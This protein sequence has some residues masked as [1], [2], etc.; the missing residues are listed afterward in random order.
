MVRRIGLLLAAVLV[1]TIACQSQAAVRKKPNI[2]VILTDDMGYADL[3][4]Q[5]QVDDILT[6]NIDR[7]A[8]TGVR[9]TSGYV[10]APQCIPSR[11]GLLTGQYQNRFGVDQNGM[12]SLE[13]REVTIA[14]RLKKAG[15]ATGMVG[16]WHLNPNWKDNEWI[17]INMPGAKPNAQGRV[18]IPGKLKSQYAPV[19]QGF[20][21][22]FWGNFNDYT[23]SYNL[24][25][26]SLKPEGEYIHEEG[27]RLDIQ[28][29][30]GLAFI[31]RHKDEPF[32]L[33]LS[34][35]APHVPLDATEKY[36][37]RF[38]GDMPERRRYCLAMMSA[39][40][41]GVGRIMKRLT[42]YH[43]D[44]NT[45]VFFIS[46]NGA[47]LKIH[48]KD[49]P[50][51]FQG[52]AWDGSLNE[53]WV[54]EKGMLSEGGIR[55][56]FIVNWKGTLPAGKV[57]DKP[58]ISL[59]VAATA[60]H[61]AG[62]PDDGQLDGVNLIPYLTGERNGLPHKALFWRFWNQAAVRVG[63]WKYLTAGNGYE[64]LFNVQS[65]QHETANLIDEHREM[66]AKMRSKL[67]DWTATLH[68]PG[69]P[70]KIGAE[71]AWYNHYLGSV[72]G[73]QKQ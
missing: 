17:A 16:K 9:M 25:G 33:Y 50:I 71:K 38:P 66:T 26:E 59:D 64:Y 1:T 51:S 70:S 69:M 20:D 67:D 28:T 62:L 53:P 45:L 4:I 13:P 65:D 3:G 57:Y 54:G 72:P 34:Y 35:F 48:K 30:A 44:E 61:L 14:E 39:M 7:L 6:P 12:G 43:I 52:S 73:D 63:K 46:D 19:V 27:F 40:D 60:N 55:V 10:T 36:L 2:I 11:A 15:Y 21:D 29:D 22:F 42:K 8:Q 47:P 24:K 5:G 32:F 18:V 56:P 58:V 41:D 68:R 23:A 49:T 31:D 37:K